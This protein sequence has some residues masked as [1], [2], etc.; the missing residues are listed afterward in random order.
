MITSKSYFVELTCQNKVYYLEYE[1]PDEAK[2][3][4][5]LESMGTAPG[6]LSRAQNL[7]HKGWSMSYV[8]FDSK[9]LLKSTVNFRDAVEK[10]NCSD[11]QI[12]LT[13]E[14]VITAKQQKFYLVVIYCPSNPNNPIAY[15]TVFTL[16][17]SDW[18]KPSLA[19][20]IRFYP[21]DDF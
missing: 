7:P 3:R 20:N 1:K 10:V 19:D 2:T 17:K 4:T 6:D 9:A 12:V 14:K 18:F 13:Y 5:F 15:V 8:T 16:L 11:Y 21:P